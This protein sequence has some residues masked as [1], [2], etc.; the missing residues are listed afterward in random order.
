MRRTNRARVATRRLRAVAVASV[1]LSIFGCAREADRVEVPGRDGALKTTAVERA[2]RRAFD[3]APPVIPHESFSVV[4]TQCHNREGLDVAGVGFAPPSP[5]EATAGLSLI[6][7]CR[8]CH[9]F[10]VTDDE[11]R[12]NSFASLRQDLRRGGRASA[13]APPVMPHSAFMRENCVACHTGPAAREEIRTSHPERIRCR[14][15]HVERQADEEFS[16]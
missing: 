8:Q 10:S 15:C 2:A 3:G 16:G 7:R 13:G 12:T 1:L 4:C 6:S 5:H 14:Q 9:V 11:F